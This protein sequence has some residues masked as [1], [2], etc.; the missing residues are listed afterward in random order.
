[1]PLSDDLRRL[2]LNQLVMTANL[3]A[4]LDSILSSISVPASNVKAGGYSEDIFLTLTETEKEEFECC[5]CYQ[6]L[7]E[8]KQCTNKH[9]F[10]GPCIF[11]WSTSSTS[12]GSDKCPMCR[13]EGEYTP[14]YQINN[15]LKHKRVKCIESNCN[16][17][18]FL[19]DYD[20]HEHRIVATPTPISLP[21]ISTR[22][23]PSHDQQPHQTLSVPTPRSG[24][25][26]EIETVESIDRAVH[27]GTDDANEITDNTP[28][29]T[30]T[31]RSVNNP[32]LRRRSLI[33]A[34]LAG[35][36]AQPTRNQRRPSDSAVDSNTRGDNREPRRA[37]L[38]SASPITRSPSARRVSNTRTSQ[39][40]STSRNNSQQQQQQQGRQEIRR[41]SSATAQNTVRQTRVNNT[42]QSRLTGRARVPTNNFRRNNNTS[43]TVQN[44]VSES[45]PT[46]ISNEDT[47]TQ[48]S[49]YTTEH[50]N[51]QSVLS[52]PRPNEGN[53]TI[54]REE[55]SEN[56]APVPRP[57]SQ[58][59]PQ[60]TRIHPSLLSGASLQT[61]SSPPAAAA[62]QITTRAASPPAAAARQTVPRT[63]TARN[64]M[65]D[66]RQR[67]F[68]RIGSQVR[69]GRHQLHNLM[70]VLSGE[71]TQS[72]S[73][74]I[75]TEPV[76]PGNHVRRMRQL[77]EIHGLGRRLGEVA[78]NLAVLM[79]GFRGS[80]ENQQ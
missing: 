5:I 59:R 80:N 7:K 74:T 55:S 6:I 42:T 3:F 66:V 33:S 10:C 44:T 70:N 15:K 48:P 64:P 67:Q 31:T 36:Q 52:R 78:T 2:E 37:P 21:S 30:V 13:A 22:T 39:R 41:N 72:S 63:P 53:F 56:L 9:H 34:S 16:W 79:S 23:A 29:E 35:S 58:P 27:S 75:G 68:L 8:A 62:R 24:A 4:V 40:S 38:Q 45:T 69:D 76:S 71:L 11:V 47:S 43:N 12:E 57:P 46:D 54:V 50:S 17:T 25:S 26:D 49:V 1:M 61:P 73:P 51:E 77:Q 32:P 14:C 19:R 65:D 28:A 60:T 20:E 18:G